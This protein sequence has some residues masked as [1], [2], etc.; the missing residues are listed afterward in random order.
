MNKKAFS[1]MAGVIIV[2]GLILIFI[3][4]A[5]IIVMRILKNVPK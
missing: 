3:F 1:K 5:M 4:A 2:I